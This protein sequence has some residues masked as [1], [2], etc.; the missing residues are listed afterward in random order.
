MD[1]RMGNYI[2]QTYTQNAAVSWFLI[3][4][5]NEQGAVSFT[6]VSPQYK[7]HTVLSLHAKTIVT[8]VRIFWEVKAELGFFFDVIIVTWW[9]DEDNAKK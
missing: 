8:C 2:L 3:G 7:Y 5:S 4:Q 1:C 6:M 9:A